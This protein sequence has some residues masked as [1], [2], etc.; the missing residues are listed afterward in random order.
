MLKSVIPEVYSLLPYGLLTS[1][2]KHFG[3]SECDCCGFDGNGSCIMLLP[4]EEE[5]IKKY[6]HLDIEKDRFG[7][8]SGTTCRV[9]RDNLGFPCSF[10]P[11]DCRM[12][13]F[14]PADVSEIDSV[15]NVTI[16]AGFP[17][18]QLESE[19]KEN[20]K[21]HFDAV[22]K[23]AIYLYE[24]DLLNWMNKASKG[25]SPKSYCRKYIV[26]VDNS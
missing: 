4:D 22:V 10:K 6:P 16:L 21:E 26:T 11:L 24:H 9:K 13:P 3:K 20:L 18:C 7:F 1:C 5:H 17:R 2:E 14:F 12:Y 19:P 23:V 25:F 8:F 15:Y